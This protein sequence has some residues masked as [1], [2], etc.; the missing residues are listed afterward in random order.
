MRRRRAVKREVNPDVKYDNLVVAKCINRIMVQGKKSTAEKIFYDCLDYIAKKQKSDDPLKVFVKAVENVKPTLELRARR[1]GGTTY[2]IPV[3]VEP[4]RRTALALK[5]MVAFARQ[6]K[7]MPMSQR[8]A[9]EFLD[10]AN[11][12]GSAVKKKVDTHKMAEANR[13]FAHFRW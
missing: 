5:W 1:V 11:N 2:Q 4:H 8:L 6:K 12:T 10:A 3:E 9:A 13:A 7:G